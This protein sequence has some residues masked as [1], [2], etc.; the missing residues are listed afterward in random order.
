[1]KK[2]ILICSLAVII[3]IA[4]AAGAYK[5]NANQKIV[6]QFTMVNGTI[7]TYA[8]PPKPKLEPLKDLGTNLN[9][10][11]EADTNGFTQDKK[12]YTANDGDVTTYWEG[13]ANAYPSE[14]TFDLTKV[15]SIK[16]VRIKLNPDPI[17][18][19]RK[20]TLSILG[21]TDNKTFTNIV[22]SKEYS[23]DPISNANVVTIEFP[24]TKVQ[25]VRFSFTANDGAT[26]GQA[27]D[28][29]IY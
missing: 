11:V 17:W 27:G 8:P 9:L 4:L 25:F 2:I 1:M 3:L 10:N 14:I 21:S 15:E 5:V 7:H 19:A 28:I 20:Q 26:A 18:A 6:T 16:A 13:E 24:E 29:E 12:P 22:E 23:F